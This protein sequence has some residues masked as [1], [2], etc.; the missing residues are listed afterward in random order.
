MDDAAF[1]EFRDVRSTLV[2]Q[3]AFID[4]AEGQALDVHDLQRAY[5]VL[6]DTSLTLHQGP[7]ASV[8]ASALTHYGSVQSAFGWLEDT[9]DLHRA[10]AAVSFLLLQLKDLQNDHEAAKTLETTIERSILM[11]RLT[12]ACSNEASIPEKV[13]ISRFS[14]LNA[15]LDEPLLPLSRNERASLWRETTEPI[16]VPE[17]ENTLELPSKQQLEREERRLVQMAQKPLPSN[18]PEACG[19]V[20]REQPTDLLVQGTFECENDK[21]E[22]HLCSLVVVRCGVICVQLLPGQR[23]VYVMGAS[24]KI[25]NSTH[26]AKFRVRVEGVSQHNGT[27]SAL[28]SVRFRAETLQDGTR[29]IEALKLARK[30]VQLVEQLRQEVEQ[31][32]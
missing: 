31:Q 9:L 28:E 20:P 8:V 4:P 13:T 7:V 11:L 32:W 25:E 15:L 26:D 18:L 24:C 17:T 19:V 5:D 29:L 14:L 10:I 16:E 23:T 30:H 21:P 27:G 2:A 6:V 1:S 12:T 3:M 22:V